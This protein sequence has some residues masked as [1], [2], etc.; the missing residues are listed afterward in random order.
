MQKSKNGQ[1]LPLSGL[2]SRK[3]ALLLFFLTSRIS[4]YLVMNRAPG[5]P[6]PC[7]FKSLPLPDF[8]CKGFRYPVSIKE[9]HWLLP[10][11]SKTPFCASPS[12]A[13]SSFVVLSTL[14]PASLMRLQHRAFN[15]FFFFLPG[16]MSEHVHHCVWLFALVLFIWFCPPPCS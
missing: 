1:S 15:I 14:I 8:L 12:R 9:G 5:L 7:G 2:T 16:K 4:W 11:V 3:K 13:Q 6:Y 10:Q